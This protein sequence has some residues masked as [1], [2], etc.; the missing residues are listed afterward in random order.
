MTIALLMGPVPWVERFYYPVRANLFYDNPLGLLVNFCV[1]AGVMYPPI[2]RQKRRSALN[3][4]SVRRTI[5]FL[6]EPGSIVGMHPEGLRNKSNN[7]YTMQPAQHG[8]GEVALKARPTVVPV[9]INGLTND[10][11]YEMRANHHPAVRQRSPVILIFGAPL[12]LGFFD[13][14]TP[15]LSVYKKAAEFFN[16]KILDLSVRERAIR[17]RAANGHISGDF[18]DGCL[19]VALHVSTP[20]QHGR[21]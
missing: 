8:V 5:G 16:D 12:D 3:K 10:F 14:Q 2:F 11:L 21:I 17:E 6:R 7:P 9:F 19:I 4:D 15:R 20:A 1:T 18:P 13:D